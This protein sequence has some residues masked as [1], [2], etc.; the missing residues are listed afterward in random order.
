MTKTA[1]KKSTRDSKFKSGDYV[2]Y[3]THGVG[4]IE[5]LED[6]VIADEKLELIVIDFEKEKMKLRVPVTK[7]Q[8]ACLF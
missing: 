4:R 8:S 2:V 5:G 7:A 6:Q 3:P 1:R